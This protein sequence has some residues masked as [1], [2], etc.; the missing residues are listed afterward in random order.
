MVLES[1]DT[2]EVVEDTVTDEVV[3][4]PGE[5]EIAPAEVV[6]ET[7]TPEPTDSV[8]PDYSSIL[9]DAPEDELLQT[10][11]MRDIIARREESTRQRT[12][13]ALMRKA[14]GDAEVQNVLTAMLARAV[15]TGD[16]TEFRRLGSQA[17]MLNRANAVYE[18]AQNYGEAVKAH[19]KID[20][21][22]HEAAVRALESKDMDT[23]ANKLTQGAIK[24]SISA[25]KLADI[26]AD[27]PIRA[28]M[29]AAQRKAVQAAVAAEL[30]AKAVQDAPKLET[31]PGSPSGFNAATVT[32]AD[33]EKINSNAWIA[34]P[35]TE[36]SALLEAA[37]RN[38]R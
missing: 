25:L 21:E 20:P 34:M 24:A 3:A 22:E 1:A 30:K 9:A 35:A 11:R 32:M 17:V 36:R 10:P 16:E 37:R 12:E 27:A 15:E 33:I 38:Q 5:T 29:A 26:P 18:V 19:Y 6:A 23:Y 4:P 2:A 8:K 28:E 14:A 13:A 31:P 7:D